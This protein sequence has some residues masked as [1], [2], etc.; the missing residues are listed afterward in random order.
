M[1]KSTTQK[2]TNMKNLFVIILLIGMT[3]CG[4]KKSITPTPPPKD[5]T[6]LK[7]TANGEAVELRYTPLWTYESDKS[8]YG[9]GITENKSGTEAPQRKLFS[10]RIQ[11]SDMVLGRTH[12][13][14]IGNKNELI[15]MANHTGIAGQYKASKS[16]AKSHATFTLTKI[17]NIDGVSKK[18]QGIFSGTVYNLNGD[19]IIIT[20]GQI[21]Y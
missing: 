15:Y 12:S 17:E 11:E 7:M 4:K 2:S 1:L 9:F 19:S 8:I 21:N 3:A 14:G 10:L 20:N 16:I 5:A 18:F 6:V 13:I